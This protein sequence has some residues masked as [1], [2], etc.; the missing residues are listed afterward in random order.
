M[1]EVYD[2][3]AEAWVRTRSGPWPPVTRFLASLRRPALVAD[4]GTGSGRYLNVEE[5]RGL[6]FAALDFSRRQ[7]EVARRSAREGVLFLRADVRLLPIR[8]SVAHAALGVAVVHH[9]LAREDRVGSMAEVRR[10]LKPGG[11][12]LISAWADGAEVFRGSRRVEGAGPRDFLVPFKERLEKPADRFFHAYA[13]GELESEA[14]EAGFGGVREW[15]EKDNRFV[16]AI[17]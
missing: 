5:A 8:D 6:R 15:T 17:G 2:T 4:V 11:R 16:E 10:V 1:E 9:F 3:I 7:L 12:A 14:L 13:E